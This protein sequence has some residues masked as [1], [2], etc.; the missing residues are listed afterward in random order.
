M[1][2]LSQ[3]NSIDSWDKILWKHLAILG[4]SRTVISSKIDI[5]KKYL[6]KYETT[7]KMWILWEKEFPVQGKLAIQKWTPFL[8]NSCHFIS[9]QALLDTIKKW[10]LSEETRKIVSVT[11]KI[12]VDEYFLVEVGNLTFPDRRR[13]RRTYPPGRR[14]RMP[15]YRLPCMVLRMNLQ[16]GFSIKNLLHLSRKWKRERNARGSMYSLEGSILLLERRRT[17]LLWDPLGLNWLVSWRNSAVE[18]ECSRDATPMTMCVILPPARIISH[19]RVRSPFRPFC[20]H[21]GLYRTLLGEAGNPRNLN[22]KNGFD[23][24][25]PPFPPV[26]P[27][28]SLQQIHLIIHCRCR[29]IVIHLRR[30]SSLPVAR[31]IIPA[32]RG[33]RVMVPVWGTSPDWA[34]WADWRFA[35]HENQR[36]AHARARAR[37]ARVCCETFVSVSR[38][39]GISLEWLDEVDTYHTNTCGEGWSI[40]DDEVCSVKQQRRNGFCADGET[41]TVVL[42]FIRKTAFIK[43]RRCHHIV[44]FSSVRLKRKYLRRAERLRKSWREK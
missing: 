41:L 21:P 39:A 3:E 34:D 17:L 33:R 43:C 32:W 2:L 26:F 9:V 6:N 22:S 36:R 16:Q 11:M 7:I 29:E 40:H 15:A 12:Y 18:S 20:A 30:W 37:A 24:I 5:L 1:S 42:N 14:G 10:M 13:S 27:L 23:V 31:T 8:W 38:Q 19:H 44:V 28:L 35:R 25:L 4:T